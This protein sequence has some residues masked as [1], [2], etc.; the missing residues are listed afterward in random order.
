MTLQ[1][2]EGGMR[3]TMAKCFRANVLNALRHQRLWLSAL[4]QTN[5]QM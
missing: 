4:K 2:E 5:G 1:G 3:L